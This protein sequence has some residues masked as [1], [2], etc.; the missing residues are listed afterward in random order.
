MLF[1]FNL[2]KD[3]VVVMLRLNF[4]LNKCKLGI[5]KKFILWEEFI[6]VFMRFRFGLLEKDL[7]ERFCVVVFIVFSICRI[8]IRFMRVELEFICI[9][10]FFKE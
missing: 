10:W 7:V 4:D 6:L 5:K 1:C 8:W 9:Y 3:K 2:L